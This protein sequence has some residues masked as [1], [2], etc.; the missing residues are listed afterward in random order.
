[1]VDSIEMLGFLAGGLTTASY[2]PQVWNLFRLRS[3]REI[4]LPFTI[5]FSLG[6]AAWLSYGVLFGIGPI[7]YWNAVT[8]ALALCMLGAKMRYGRHTIVSGHTP[9]WKVRIA[10]R[11]SPD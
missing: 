5:L 6:I 4:S 8:M 7:I 9:D 2:V 1:M 11:S 10:G 3:A